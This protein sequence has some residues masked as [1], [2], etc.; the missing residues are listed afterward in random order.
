M[1]GAIMCGKTTM[2]RSGT[3]GSVLR[4]LVMKLELSLISTLLLSGWGPA[5]Q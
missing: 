5:P 3:N 2:S 4:V 1:N